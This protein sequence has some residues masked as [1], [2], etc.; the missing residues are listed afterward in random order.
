VR[1][2]RWIKR[3]DYQYDYMLNHRHHSSQYSWVLYI[4]S[5]V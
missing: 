3:W 2:K 5:W 4:V 1:R